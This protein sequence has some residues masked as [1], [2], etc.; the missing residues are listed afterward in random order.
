M[1]LVLLHRCTHG[2]GPSKIELSVRRGSSQE[3]PQPQPRAMFHLMAK[4][5]PISTEITK[6]TTKLLFRALVPLPVTHNLQIDSQKHL[7]HPG[8]RKPF[9]DLKMAKLAWNTRVIK[10]LT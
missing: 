9:G 7:W 5:I 1:I 4:T 8:L 2:I 3:I 6:I 10:C